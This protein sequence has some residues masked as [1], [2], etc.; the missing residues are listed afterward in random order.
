MSNS[1][2]FVAGAEDTNLGSSY[3]Q[4]I[5][6]S[7]YLKLLP[8]LLLLIFAGC[9]NQPASPP[10]SDKPLVVT[11]IFPLYDFTRF[12]AADRM[13]VTLLL[14]PGVEP[15]HFE[16]RPTDM[17]DIRRS[18]LFIYTSSF[19]EPWAK[20]VIAGTDSTKTQI[21]AA[22]KGVQLLK[23][24][25]H[26]GHHEHGLQHGDNAVDPHVWLD[27]ENCIFMVKQ[28]TEKLCAIDPDGNQEYQKRAFELTAKLS[29]LDQ[30]YQNRLAN[31]KS[32]VVIHGGHNAFG[33][34]G[35]R[36]NLKYHAAAG[37]SADIEPTPRRMA[38]LVQLVK[39]NNSHAVFS[40]EL[41]SPRIAEAI[42]RETGAMVLKLHGAHNLA[43]D[44]FERGVT[45]FDLMDENLENLCTGLSCR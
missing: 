31:C 41:L 21:L 43:K 34:L 10:K 7:R 9:Q 4:V 19:M 30:R 20:R 39:T 35:H 17:A 16:P 25:K 29:D 36:Y 32:R 5:A 6:L 42:A 27:F 26:D 18:A 23:L 3:S 38:E 40:E 8:L 28:I 14:P 45:F 1:K 15:H 22:A 2:Y 12:L 24:A 37:V 13:E 11:T 44:E 33:Y